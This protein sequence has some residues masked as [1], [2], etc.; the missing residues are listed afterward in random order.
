MTSARAH[1]GVSS[2]V[3]LAWVSGHEATAICGARFVPQ[4][5]ERDVPACNA[6]R[7]VLH[8]GQ[9]LEARP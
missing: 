7:A 9:A 6:C 2:E 3:I 8:F 4:I 5:G 1:I